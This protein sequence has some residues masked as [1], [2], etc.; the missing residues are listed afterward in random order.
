MREA[1]LLVLCLT[2]AR[3]THAK[4]PPRP[5][6]EL[7]SIPVAVS[8]STTPI[9]QLHASGVSTTV[10]Q[11][12]TDMGYQVVNDP[13]K[14]G[15]RV[16]VTL[17]ATQSSISIPYVGVRQVTEVRI[18]AVLSSAWGQRL[19]QANDSFDSD[20]GR[21]NPKVLRRVVLKLIEEGKLE[22]FAVEHKRRKADAIA[23]TQ[24]QAAADRKAEGDRRREE[25]RL[26]RI[27]DDQSWSEAD[28]AGCM[29][30][31]SLEACDRINAYLRDFADG[32]HSEEARD[33]KMLG[34]PRLKVLADHKAWREADVAACRKAQVPAACDGVEGYLNDFSGGIHLAEAK[35][36]LKSAGPRLAAL[37]KQQ[38]AKNQAGETID[39]LC[40]V[41]SQLDRL[42]RASAL[43]KR[44]DRESGTVSLSQRRQQ[45]TA[46]IVLGDKKKR[47][48]SELARDGI[49]FNRKTDCPADTSED[50]E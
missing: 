29:A 2:L 5:S 35:S 40:D 16:L 31:A 22:A 47:L 28:P 18:G 11:A 43:S 27:T 1:A 25:L 46:K 7:G 23:A 37:R 19:S 36:I 39:D 6:P 44:V 33:A 9:A 13:E 48:T 3:T 30:A 15:L 49:R 14:A 8:V 45:A 12:F 4:P 41:L 17:D 20:D 24:R 50:E 32:M 26:R 38:E 21:P 42:E 10:A 34:E